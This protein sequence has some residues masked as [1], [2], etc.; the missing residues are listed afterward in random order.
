MTSR[1]TGF[2]PLTAAAPQLTR[3]TSR[4]LLLAAGLAQVLVLLAT[5]GRLLGH[6]GQYL[7][8]NHYDGIRSYYA[9]ATVLRQPLS[10]GLLDHGTNYPFGEYLF[11]T[12]IAPGF[13]IPLHGLVRAV[14]GL[15]PY[16]AYA[17]DLFILSGF[18]L[19]TVLLLSMLRRLAVPAWLALVLSVALPWLAP[20]AIRLGVG[21]LA[22]AYV[23]AVLGPLWVLQGLY[24]AWRAG[25]PLGRWWLGLGGALVAASWVHFYYLGIMG[26]WVGL[27]LVLWLGR[28]ALAARPWRALAGRAAAMLGA[29][30]V[31]TF[32]LLQVLDK[33]AGE[34]PAGADGYD[35]IEW[36]FQVG[37]LFKGY[38]FNKVRFL[39]ER[40][41]GVP[42]ESS[43]YLGAFAL[44]GLVVVAVLAWVSRARRRRG[45]A[46]PALLPALPPATEPSRAWL[47][48]LLL[49]TLPLVLI[50]LGE[51]I[52]LD[53]DY[54]V[55]HNYLN[56]FLWLH[57]L[58]VRVTQ[59]RALG[60]F[61]W[62]FWWA[63]LLGFSW[64]AGLA[65]RQ[66]AARS[67]RGLQA[68][69]VLLAGLAVVDAVHATRHY[70]DN[71]Q[72]DNLLRAPATA[73]IH[74]LVG[75]PE[76]GRY[77]AILP[78]PYWHQGTKV[79]DAPYLGVDPDDPHCNNGYQLGLITGLPLMSNKAG[80]TPGYQAAELQS[81]FRPGGPDPAL[82]AR[83]DPRP[84]LV[85]LD[86]AYYD[87]RNNY[88]RE[89]LK[90]RPEVLALFERV[91][92]FIQ[93][94]HMRRLRHQGSWSL[95]EW[96]ARK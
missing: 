14:P 17:F 55:V 93:E 48:L 12:D 1:D 27:F 15:E 83:L 40:T 35:W 75:W 63:L 49:A 29:T 21:H 51:E 32:G 44:Y 56:P 31:F 57:K 62:P 94:Q 65:W 86:T 39:F 61:I 34:R 76:P 11:Y 20:Q 19:G 28:E 91:P 68:L 88:Y 53:N 81:M 24:G 8:V 71:S 4:R 77:Q 69:W 72:R 85:F 37:S 36:K 58:T 87:G 16:G 2:A 38:V 70:H 89:Q 10:Q 46:G 64:Y 33:R 9:L 66:A 26:M 47:H 79:D 67:S 45:L 82:L 25:R 54:Y 50:A 95:Y 92:A 30:L 59:F 41:A 96:Q 52:H 23:P 42:Y 78:L 6:P 18:A 90:D 60:R 84:I 80:R 73:A 3:R 13:S 74:E 22:L 5:F 43:A 7:L